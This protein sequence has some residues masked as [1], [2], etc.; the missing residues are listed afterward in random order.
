MTG[1]GGERGRGYERRQHR[2][3]EGV[4]GQQ[5]DRIWE[6]SQERTEVRMGYEEREYKK[7][8]RKN[9]R[10]RSHCSLLQLPCGSSGPPNT[11]SICPSLGPYRTPRSNGTSLLT[12]SLAKN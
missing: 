3:G 5:S 10:H 1:W 12:A 4:T 2:K 8:G 7:N 9:M 11:S 6:D